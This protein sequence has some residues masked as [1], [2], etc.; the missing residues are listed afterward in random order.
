MRAADWSSGRCS[1][2]LPGQVT[3]VSPQIGDIHS[4][5]NALIDRPSISI[6]AYGANI[7]AIER[8][9]FVLET[10]ETKLFALGYANTTLPNLWDRSAETR[11]CLGI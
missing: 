6:H 1:H 2:L 7:G 3:G 5:E 8:H 9:M 10:G 4:V 11:A